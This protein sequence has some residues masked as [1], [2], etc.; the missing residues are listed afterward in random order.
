MPA[1]DKAEK[2]VIGVEIIGNQIISTQTIISK[3]RTRK[4]AILRQQTINDD[5]KRLYSGYFDDIQIKLD[6]LSDGYKIYVTIEKPVIR[7]N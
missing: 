5:I 3:M 7:G 4:G 6:E 1:A 2:K